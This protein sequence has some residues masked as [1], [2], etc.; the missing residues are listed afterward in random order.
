M[1]MPRTFQRSNYQCNGNPP[2]KAVPMQLAWQRH[3]WLAFAHT[4][5]SVTYARLLQVNRLAYPKTG[6]AN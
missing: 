1:E 3:G 2:S 6:A 4:P 5:V